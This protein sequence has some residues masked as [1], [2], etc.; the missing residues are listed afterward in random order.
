MTKSTVW[1]TERKKG[2]AYP[3]TADAVTALTAVTTATTIREVLDILSTVVKDSHV[4]AAN[5]IGKATSTEY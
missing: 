1:S 4:V 5:Q 3:L 2:A